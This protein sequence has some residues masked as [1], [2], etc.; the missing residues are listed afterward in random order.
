ML[1][2]LRKLRD[3][4]QWLSDWEETPDGRKVP[5]KPVVKNLRVI[6]LLSVFTLFLF[7]LF[8]ALSLL[9]ISFIITAVAGIAIL[10]TGLLIRKAKNKLAKRLLILIFSVA[11]MGIT[12]AEGLSSG[13]YFFYFA[14]LIGLNFISD[15][16][17]KEV[18]L[19]DYAIII[20]S[21]LVSYTC[22]PFYSELQQIPP[23]IIRTNQYINA[24]FSAGLTA[25]LSY[26]MVRSNFAREQ[27][28]QENQ[29]YL[30]TVYNTSLDGVFIVDIET[31]N[32]MGCNQQ[33]L[34]MFETVHR[35]S[36][37][38]KSACG[39]F[40]ELLVAEDNQL[41]AFLCDVNSRW[42]G[43]LT[44]IT[45]AGNEFAGYVSILPFIYGGKVLKKMNILDINDIKKARTELQAAKEKA[46]LA[47]IAKSRFLSNMSHE[48]RTP[49]NGIIGTTN[50]MLQEDYL[51]AQ[52]QNFEVLK[53]SSEHI[54]SL[55]NDVLDFNKLEA[56]K[57]DL[58]IQPRNMQQF[59]EKIEAFFRRQF[60]EKNIEFTVVTDTTLN[61]ELVTDF[62]RLNQVLTNL[63]ANALK[64]TP[65]G[66]VAFFVKLR[67]A[68]SELATVEFSVLDTGIGISEQ[69]VG[70]IF[71]S[72]TQADVDTTREYGGTG[73]G[74][75]I[76][77]KIVEKLGGVLKVETELRKGSKFY[78][79]L[80]MPVH[81]SEAG[82]FLNTGLV[83]Q[84]V[85]LEGLNILVAEDNPV[86]M[87]VTQRFL[88]KWN[89]KVFKAKNGLEA[90]DLFREQEF[91]I[92]LID[93]EM[94]EMDG[95]ILLS[96]IRKIN[97]A[98]PAL[99]FT[100]A[101]FENMK[102]TLRAHG[103]NDYLQKP[104]R[105]EDLHRKLIEYIKPSAPAN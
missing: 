88:E 2:Y 71:E 30:N 102:Y 18:L 15:Y 75:F 57:I 97:P 67:K 104:F 90:L 24:F 80:N 46:E 10:L 94:P 89:T 73:L 70:K 9:W 23:D 49:L 59:I 48:L 93:L 95:Y 91:D 42:Q 79:T 84:L 78:F 60:E 51:P 61:R 33:S 85:S 47:T 13:G 56:D 66:G 8:N 63:L 41:K 98:I 38:G 58:D 36:M 82:T 20:V 29:E 37:I 83:K 1:S 105:P 74:L 99:A 31:S 35:E 32:I 76:S 17:E 69:N 39:Y 22:A 81:V 45:A 21:F 40:K 50:L 19:Y 103:F 64:F 72:F 100:A 44:C 25:F 62:T 86:N 16:K 92:L 68:T 77:R 96:E 55:V 65:R 101:V 7:S 27:T 14:I 6:H 5:I 26:M 11:L 52:K 4:Y 54:L 87:M 3:Q 34:V 43:E 53:F 28:L 12:F